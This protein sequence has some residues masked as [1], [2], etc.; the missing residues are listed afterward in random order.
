M[1]R[2]FWWIAI[3]FVLYAGWQRFSDRRPPPSSAVGQSA[4]IEIYTTSRC[5]Y[6]KRAKTYMDKH[7]IAYLEK[8]VETDSAL[9]REFHERGGNGVPYFFI[10]GEPLRGWEPARF[11]QA[12]SRGS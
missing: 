3:A 9:L 4:D 10:N 2:Y 12:L 5:G 8:N 1:G 6:C 11:E 7:G